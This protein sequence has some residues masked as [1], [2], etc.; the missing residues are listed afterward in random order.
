MK[1]LIV[2][3]NSATADILSHMFAEKRIATSQ[4]LST[5]RALEQLSR[6]KFEAILLD[7]ESIPDCP[8]IL[9]KLPR[10]NK[11]AFVIAL[12]SNEKR[13]VVESE[14]SVVVEGPLASEEIRSVLDQAYDRMLRDSQSYFRLRVAIPVWVRRESGTVLQCRTLNISQTGLAVTAPVEFEVG[15]Q[16]NVGFAIP[17]TDAF[18]RG[19]GTVIWDDKH[20][21]CGIALRC[22]DGAVEQTFIEWLRDNFFRAMDT[23]TSAT[24]APG[25]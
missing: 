5:S 16:I 6:E 8:D 18:V 7:C 14:A 17:N 15:E 4:A 2:G 11:S 25:R 19:T 13:N 3:T 20:G 23:E 22:T 9:T 10:P 1:A 21:Q 24:G 12:A